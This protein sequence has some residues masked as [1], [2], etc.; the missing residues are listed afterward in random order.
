MVATKLD[1]NSIALAIRQRLGAEIAEKQR[2]NPRYHP[3]LRIIQ[4]T[5]ENAQDSRK[6]EKKGEEGKK[7]SLVPLLPLL[8]TS[9][10]ARIV[11][12]WLFPFCSSSWRPFRFL[13]VSPP[14]VS[15][16]Y[17][18]LTHMLIGPT[19]NRC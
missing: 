5:I 3:S 19:W 18:Y 14:S 16:S 13:Y 7:D 8:P 15:Y 4:G 1:G 10:C 12:N 2:Q 6:R 9:Y 17:A 11:T